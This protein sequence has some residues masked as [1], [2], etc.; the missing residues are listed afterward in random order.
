M[1]KNREIAKF[2]AGFVSFHGVMHAALLM[3]DN[4]P[5]ELFGIVHTPVVNTLAVI[6]SVV[7]AVVLGWYGWFKRP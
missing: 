2:F 5:L 4:P 1:S 7:L 3:E 6:F